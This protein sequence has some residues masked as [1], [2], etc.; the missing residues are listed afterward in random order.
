MSKKWMLIR[1]EKKSVRYKHILDER[2]L[3]S[4]KEKDKV[5]AGKSRLK[6]ATKK[7][8][9]IHPWPL[10]LKQHIRVICSQ[11]MKVW[12]R[13]S[14]HILKIHVPHL[15]QKMKQIFFWPNIFFNMLQYPCVC[16]NLQKYQEVYKWNIQTQYISETRRVIGYTQ[17]K[18]C[19]PKYSGEV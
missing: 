8:K 15:L 19:E 3:G 1:K 9:R 4:L 18:M 6:K 16:I 5:N 13:K 12:T 7:I 2:I 10:F 17:W 11:L 14:I